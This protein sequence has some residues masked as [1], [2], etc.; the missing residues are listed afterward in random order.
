MNLLTGDPKQ[1]KQ[2]CTN[3]P[4]ASSPPKTAHI[5]RHMFARQRFPAAIACKSS[6]SC[7]AIA[8]LLFISSSL[9]SNMETEILRGTSC[10]Y[11]Y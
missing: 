7:D 3:K 1:T 4:V 10:S 8:T 9:L 5:A 6:A 2:C 11:S